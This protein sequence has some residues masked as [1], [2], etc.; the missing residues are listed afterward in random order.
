LRKR[1]VRSG[2][3]II[4]VDQLGGPIIAGILA[5]ATCDH[6][7]GSTVLAPLAELGSLLPAREAPG[8]A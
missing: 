3:L 2:F 1:S 5:D 7:A 8:A 6:W 4:T